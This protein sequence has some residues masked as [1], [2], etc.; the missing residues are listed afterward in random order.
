MSNINPQNIDG[1]Y[2]IA[3]Q[4]NNSQ[5]FRDNFTNTVNNFTFAATELT[6]LQNNAILKAP[7][8]SVGQTSVNNN[9]NQ[10]QLVGAQLAQTTLTKID[11]GTVSSGGNVT[12]D[13]SQASFQTVSISS[14]ATLAFA[15]T[16]PTTNLYTQLR[17]QVTTTS[18]TVLTLPS[19]VSTN[20]SSIGGASGQ[21]ITLPTGVYLFEFST[22]N[23]GTTVAIQDV[24]RQYN[25]GIMY[26]SVNYITANVSTSANLSTTT[27]DNYFVITGTN[28]V[29][30]INMPTSPVNGQVVRFGANANVA[31]SLGT[32]TVS[33][34]FAGV[35]TVGTNYRY[36]YSSTYSTWFRT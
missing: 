1:T 5:G 26:T 15:T 33:P 34:T 24:W 36:T 27:T 7:L 16:W 12:V 29:L 19:S 21:N 8:G 23:N 3:G 30:T 18:S 17:L 25:Q 22:Y 31:Y 20:L 28:P 9:L 35:P 2:P 14:T 11:L 13:W 32:G 4:D 10:T 6:D